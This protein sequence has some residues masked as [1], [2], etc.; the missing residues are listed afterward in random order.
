MSFNL[1]PSKQGRED[2]FSRKIK[3]L[4]YPSLVFNNSNVLQVSSQKHLGVSLEVKLTFDK[5]LN[6]VLKRVNKKKAF[7]AASEF[8]TNVSDNYHIQSFF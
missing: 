8:I 2:I 4:S 1:D 3:R 6:N 5:H 7:Y